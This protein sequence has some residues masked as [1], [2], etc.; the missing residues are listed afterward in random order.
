MISKVIV[1][2]NR[3]QGKNKTSINT[4][5]SH[6]SHSIVKADDNNSV[7]TTGSLESLFGQHSR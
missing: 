4:P 7:H 2:S 1:K 5:I 3:A 6:R